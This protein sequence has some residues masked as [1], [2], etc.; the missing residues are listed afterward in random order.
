[1]ENLKSYS[2]LE[3]MNLDITYIKNLYKDPYKILSKH[4]FCLIR[5][6]KDTKTCIFGWEPMQQFVLDE[7]N[8]I[9]KRWKRSTCLRY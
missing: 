2:H 9:I 3:K 1:M 7:K 6:I 4:A 8:L 5:E